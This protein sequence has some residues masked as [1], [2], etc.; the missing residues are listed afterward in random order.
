M[1]II[2]SIPIVQNLCFPPVSFKSLLR[3]QE[4]FSAQEHHPSLCILLTYKQI[5]N[6]QAKNLLNDFV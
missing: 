6:I 2:D 3:F 5:G 4:V 1:V